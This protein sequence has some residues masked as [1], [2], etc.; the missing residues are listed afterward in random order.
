MASQRAGSLTVTAIRLEGL[1]KTFA[2]HDGTPLPV[3]DGLTIEA[4][5]GE[6]V[7]L[8]GPSGS[9]KSTTLDILAGLTPRD[10]G[11]VL[12]DGREDL[13]PVVFGYV[14]QQPRLLNW[15]SARQ[16]LE[17][18]LAARDVDVAGARHRVAAELSLVGLS[19]FA[20]A[21]PLTLSGGMRQRVA[22]AR[23]LVIDP[24]VL[25]MDE[26][27]SSLDELTARRLRSELLRIW[28]RERH[29]VLFVTHN[30]LEAAFLADRIYVISNRPARVV[31]CV[32]VGVPR[33]R[34]PEDPS[35][36][37]VQRQVIDLLEDGGAATHDA[38]G[39]P[40]RPEPVASPTVSKEP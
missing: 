39:A 16:N 10:G 1:S 9:G 20:D 21:Y 37:A 4:G 14:F 27:F 33:P 12:A 34:S 11:R 8:L 38:P 22:I 7:C 19:D 17:F 5:D 29:T 15:R 26:P 35:L 36:L 28:E 25:L 3:L 30:A 40:A 6:F 18:A 32:P 13:R 2:R 23:A 31:G 24:D